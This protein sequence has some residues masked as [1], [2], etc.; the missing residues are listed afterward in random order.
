MNPGTE[1]QLFLDNK[2]PSSVETIEFLAVLLTY[3]T[4]ID[5]VEYTSWIAL[6]SGPRSVQN[7]GGPIV[8]SSYRLR[9]VNSAYREMC[10][11]KIDS[12]SLS[13]ATFDS[14]AWK[15]I[16]PEV[17]ICDTE[18]N[19]DNSRRYI[20]ERKTEEVKLS[21]SRIKTI[22]WSDNSRSIELASGEVIRLAEARTEE[23]RLMLWQAQVVSLMK[24]HIP[25]IVTRRQLPKM[26]LN[27]VL[28]NSGVGTTTLINTIK[29]RE[30]ARVRIL[31][32]LPM[33][34]DL[35]RLKSMSATEWVRDIMILN[36][37]NIRD[38]TE[39][40]KR[41][42][43]TIDMVDRSNCLG[44]WIFSKV[45]LA[46]VADSDRWTIYRVGGPKTTV[47][48]AYLNTMEAKQPLN[49]DNRVS[50]PKITRRAN[51][52]DAPIHDYPS[53]QPVVIE[54]A[55]NR[56]AVDS[57]ANTIRYSPSIG[58]P[59]S[60]TWTPRN[61][62]LLLT[63]KGHINKERYRTWFT[64]HMMKTY[65]KNGEL[66]HLAIAHESPDTCHE[67]NHTHVLFYTSDIVRSRCTHIFEWDDELQTGYHARFNRQ[68][69]N[70]E[71]IMVL[72]GP[73][74]VNAALYSLGAEDRDC[75]KHLTDDNHLAYRTVTG[76]REMQITYD[77]EYGADV[78]CKHAIVKVKDLVRW[79]AEVAS[80]ML[81]PSIKERSRCQFN[82]LWLTPCSGA[83]TLAMAVKNRSRDDFHIIDGLPSLDSIGSIQAI[84][85]QEWSRHTLILDVGQQTDYKRMGQVIYS[86]MQLSKKIEFKS[87]WIICPKFDSYAVEDWSNW[88]L[89]K[90]ES[91]WKKSIVSNLERFEVDPDVERD[92]EQSDCND[93][94]YNSDFE[95]NYEFAE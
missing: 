56:E 71:Q 82:L 41:L 13:Y 19:Q 22:L 35:D 42:E 91:D 80:L 61:Q 20:Q 65:C 60:K 39:M 78:V 31:S 63:Y 12:Q 86:L 73:Q 62:M 48:R 93:E 74:E 79:Q 29:N 89:Y 6:C 46:P 64:S 32:G 76:K 95:Y 2:V 11:V 55:H 69:M 49:I 33:R 17:R 66:N 57:A 14:L 84:G 15:G 27:F 7:T 30:P 70:L 44:F 25:M 53:I 88:N 26:E 5:P 4:I 8:P 54:P 40:D 38:H 51:E 81:D 9:I 21:D 36:L 37:T 47:P 68:G 50:K 59:I 67:F 58:T 3:P 28:V 43:Q 77:K 72:K 23:L 34:D 85:D 24:L 92:I 1:Y 94:E 10:I 52:R 45:L 83:T 87:L 16:E 90:A 75:K 18:V